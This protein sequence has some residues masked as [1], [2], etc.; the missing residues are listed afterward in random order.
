MSK[1]I[2]SIGLFLLISNLIS[3]A[4][5]IPWG[6][7]A[8]ALSITTPPVIDGV[9]E[10]ECWKNAPVI[11]D[12]RT[13]LSQGYRKVADQT[14]VRICYDQNAIYFAWKVFESK[15]EEM[16]VDRDIKEIDI[17]VKGNDYIQIY[18]DT[19]NDQHTYYRIA[20]NPAGC[21]ADAYGNKTEGG[22][23]FS[24][25]F[26]IDSSSWNCNPDIRIGSFNGGWTVEIALRFSDLLFDE[27]T[28][29]S[30]WGIRLDRFQARTK[31]LSTFTPHRGEDWGNTYGGI[32]GRLKNFKIDP[33]PYRTVLIEP[34]LKFADVSQD[35]AK[36]VFTGELK[37]LTGKDDSFS[38]H[39]TLTQ[40]RKRISH[41]EINVS[42]KAEEAK[43]IEVPLTQSLFDPSSANPN[44]AI[45]ARTTV[46]DSKEVKAENLVIDLSIPLRIE[47]SVLDSKNNQRWH[48]MK[49]FS[50]NP[51]AEKQEIPILVQRFKFDGRMFRD[52]CDL[53][54]RD[55]VVPIVDNALVVD[56]RLSESVW[57]NAAF[58]PAGQWHTVAF[59]GR[60]RMITGHVLAKEQTEAFFLFTVDGLYAGFRCYDSAMASLKT[61]AK[62]D[63]DPKVRQD[64][65]IRL[66]IMGQRLLVNANGVRY[67]F[68]WGGRWKAATAKEDN[69]WTAEIFVPFSELPF[70]TSFFYKTGIPLET[71][72][73]RHRTKTREDSA[74]HFVWYWHWIHSD[75]AGNGNILWGLDNIKK[76]L[77]S[78]VWNISSPAIE[79]KASS[80]GIGIG[81]QATIKNETNVDTNIKVEAE[82]MTP[83]GK[84]YAQNG[85]FNFPN[86]KEIPVSIELTGYKKEEGPHYLR[87]TLFDETGKKQLATR[88][89]KIEKVS[90]ITLEIRKPAYR[91]TLFSGT[92]S[93]NVELAI[94]LKGE[95]QGL[96][97][98]LL[99]V[100]VISEGENKKILAR[101]I[102]S[103]EPGENFISF[104]ASNFKTGR[105]EIIASIFAKGSEKIDEDRRVLSI[106]DTTPNTVWINED[107]RLFIGDK[108]F[109]AIGMY[110][111]HQKDLEVIADAGFNSTCFY[112]KSDLFDQAEKHGIKVFIIRPA[113]KDEDVIAA[114]KHPATLMWLL[115]EEIGH[116]PEHVKQYLRLSELDPYHPV[117]TNGSYSGKSSL[118]FISD[119][120]MNHIYPYPRYPDTSEQALTKVLNTAARIRNMVNI[121]KNPATKDAPGPRLAW[122]KKPWFLWPQY[123]YGGRWISG[124]QGRF[125][126]LPEMRLHCWSA[127]I[128]G[129]A[130]IYFWA[131]WHDYTNPRMNP[132]LFEGVR[133]IAGEMKALYDFLVLPDSKELVKIPDGLEKEF[134]Y[135]VRKK[136]KEFLFAGYYAGKEEKEIICE[137]SDAKIPSLYAWPEGKKIPVTKGVFSIQA[138]MGGLYIYSTKQPPDSLV[139]KKMLSDPVFITSYDYKP[140]AGN[141]FAG[142]GVTSK[143]GYFAYDIARFAL[144]NDPDTFWFTDEWNDTTNMGYWSLK[145]PDYPPYLEWKKK[146][147]TDW[148]EIDMGKVNK[149]S[150][151]VIYTWKPRY[152]PD[153]E[154]MTL[155]DF[156]IEYY[157]GKGNWI[158][159]KEVRKNKNEK[160][161]VSF[162]EVQTQKIR[163]TVFSTG[164]ISEIEGYEI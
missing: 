93:R 41:Q 44:E 76:Q 53:R 151:M 118:Y 78:F 48:L 59:P 153:P 85:I 37:N 29:P 79:E 106:I 135:T 133:A 25:E 72:V 58:I 7:E 8:P 63:G 132:K 113:S 38:V 156:D 139:M 160:I 65:H 80:N 33:L 111:V 77:Y 51:A 92:K 162:P 161:E 148:I 39:I 56:G 115:G 14:E 12:F 101:E 146:N 104:D 18:L 19:K 60:G 84:I 4:Q 43:K 6:K 145:N 20:I 103:P 35:K 121:A 50:L 49:T 45:E 129:A 136:D 126:T 120:M 149:L 55:L 98:L 23:D 13:P 102:Q 11:T 21:I 17:F 91:A 163:L 67:D 117:A 74:P 9:L 64:D 54:T 144:D 131:Y 73:L 90:A 82:V 150:R 66:Q 88:R 142:A 71:A 112:F 157:D 46:G 116:N 15:P 31:E 95:K 52:G 130:G 96:S 99:K 122:N 94:I 47:I 152:Y 109:F 125:L 36:C 40:N 89:V 57:K 75:R 83:S 34:L 2:I 61:E 155:S 97:E 114:S 159:L 24:T 62:E 110:G 141:I 68:D 5:V 70:S 10:D 28:V 32:F 3:F 164:H 140:K 69:A 105:Y 86:N 119:V 128:E 22:W 123:F 30:D 158:K 108:P 26:G 107:G 124:G 137:I 81:F 154:A 16:V 138:K 134:F 87:V 147:P 42:I 100:E 143:K 127:V 27:K 1:K